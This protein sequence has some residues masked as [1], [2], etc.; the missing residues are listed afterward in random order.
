MVAGA[1]STDAL[2]ATDS[3]ADERLNALKPHP[4]QIAVA[5]ALRRLLAGSA[6]RASHVQCDRV[7]DPYSFRCQPQVIGACLDLID[8][9]ERTLLIEANAVT[10]NPLV[11]EDGSEVVSGGNFHGQP[12][13]FAADMVALA[14]AET[15]SLSERR[16]AALVAGEMS[17]LPPFLAPDPGLDSGFML[18]HVTAAAH[19]RISM[20]DLDPI[21]RSGGSS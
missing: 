21:R 8:N 13:A 16:I 19:P 7:Q 10:E 6:I 17:S 9:A 11:F 12:V 1:L 14:I 5:A 4:G 20:R 2:K 15:G 3:F 18:A